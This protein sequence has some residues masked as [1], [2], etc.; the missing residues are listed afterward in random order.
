MHEI[1]HFKLSVSYIVHHDYNTLLIDN[2]IHGVT[3]N[4]CIMPYIYAHILLKHTQSF[5]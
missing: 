5:K 2:H 1:P 4:I 3:Y